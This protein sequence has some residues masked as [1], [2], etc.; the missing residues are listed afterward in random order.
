[1]GMLEP[2]DAGTVGCWDSGDGGNLVACASLFMASCT[3]PSYPGKHLN[4]PTHPSRE[5]YVSLINLN[6]SEAQVFGILC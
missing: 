2:W 3:Q 1:M 4:R 6:P 5:P